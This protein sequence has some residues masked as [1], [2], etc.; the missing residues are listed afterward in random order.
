[1]AV[2]V[3]TLLV[4]DSSDNGVET[5]SAAMLYSDVT[6]SSHVRQIPLVYSQSSFVCCKMMGVRHH[7]TMDCNGSNGFQKCLAETLGIWVSGTLH[8]FTCTVASKVQG[9]PA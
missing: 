4:C 6:G 1:V 5:A 9:T 8:D 7:G 2:R 3:R